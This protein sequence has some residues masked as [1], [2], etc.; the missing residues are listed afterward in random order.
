MARTEREAMADPSSRCRRWGTCAPSRSAQDS[1]GSEST[2]T[3]SAGL[4][5]AAPAGGARAV[6]PRTA[7]AT[8]TTM[9]AAPLRPR[10]SATSRQRPSGAAGFPATVHAAMTYT[11]GH[12]EPVLR[13]HRWRTAENS[14][15]YLLP[16]LRAD[17]TLLDVGCG[18]GSIT[19]DLA[20]RVG[21]VVGVDRSPEAVGAARADHPG[22]DFRVADL[23]DLDER[24][25]V[26]HAHQVLQHLQDP[27]AALARL[28]SLARL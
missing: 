27:V 15:A 28:A 22:I 24:F 2:R 4:R 7:R 13:S 3:R 19:A 11:H 21:R 26:V 23:H 5:A 25:D 9:T 18:P 12:Q 6:V 20:D 16:H 10:A 8:A 14:C 17:M 1:V